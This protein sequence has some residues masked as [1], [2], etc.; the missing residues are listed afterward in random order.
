M[1]RTGAII[2]ADLPRRKQNRLKGYD[3]SQNGAY[4]VTICSYNRDPLLCRIVGDGFPVPKV[5]VD[6]TAQGRIIDHFIRGIP[7]AYSGINIEKYVVLPN[8]IH[9][10]LLICR[11]GNPSPTVGTVISRLKYQTTKQVNLLYDTPGKK[12]WQRSYH[13]HIIRD[14]HDY[15]MIWQYIDNNPSTWAEDC[16]YRT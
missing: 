14:E 5:S 4:F 8:H 16:F 9:I 13:D 15:E 3:Y 12:L 2:A 10:L 11:T 6:L 1:R 7:E